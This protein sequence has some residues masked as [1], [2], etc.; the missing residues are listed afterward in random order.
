MTRLSAL[1]RS[2][3][4]PC[5]ENPHIVTTCQQPD[6]FVTRAGNEPS[7]SL[8][9]HQEKAYIHLFLFYTWSF[10]TYSLE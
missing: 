1:T 5:H 7:R 2:S 9:F 8:Q 10:L 3:N 6:T 4:Y